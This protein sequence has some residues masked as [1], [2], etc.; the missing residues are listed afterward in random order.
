[1]YSLPENHIAEISLI[2][3]GGGYGESLV[4][5]LG[6]QKWVVID[7]CV[8]NNT[9][10]NLPLEYLKSIGV[11]LD[12]VVLILVTH[13]HDDHC[14]GISDILAECKNARLAMSPVLD[15]KKFLNYV[16]INEEKVST[17]ESN[18]SYTEFVKCISILIEER[19]QSYKRASKDRSLYEFNEGKINSSIISL[20]PSDHS[21]EMYEFVLTDLS[22]KYASPHIKGRKEETNHKSVVCLIKLGEHRALLGADMEVH[23]DTRLG[24]LS[25]LNELGSLDKKSTYFKI[26]HHGSETGYHERIWSELLENSPVS[27]ITPWNANMKLPTIEMLHQYQQHTKSLFKTSKVT[28]TKK[29]KKRSKEVSKLMMRLNY[30]PEEIV[31]SLGIIQCRINIT[32]PHDSWRIELIGEALKI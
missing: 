9:G 31:F 16:S 27:T 12:N 24:W 10:E 1:M 15:S 5:H 6:N 13:W 29:P 11:N 8:N 23:S 25:I 30:K 18:S 20:S 28:S 2:G 17:T 21:L 14:K 7:S 32:D 4:I 3:T 22:K 19:K 26:S